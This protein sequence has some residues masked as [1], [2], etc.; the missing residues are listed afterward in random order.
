MVGFRVVRVFDLVQTQG[1]PLPEVPVGLVQG[2]LPSHWEHVSGLITDGPG[3]QSVNRPPTP[4]TNHE[5]RQQPRRV[6]PAKGDP[7]IE[8][9]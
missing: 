8:R 9:S 3:H 4:H 2:D 1:E 5:I 6:L 7:M